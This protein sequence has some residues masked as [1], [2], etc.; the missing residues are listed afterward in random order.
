M[1]RSM[2]GYGRCQEVIDG[3]DITVEIRSVN[4]RYFE[5]SSRV[6]RVYGYLDEK[7]KSY[8]QSG[9]SRGKVEVGV[10][11]INLN[12]AGADVQIN[13][14]L[15]AAYLNSLRSMGKELGLQDDVTITSLARFNDIFTVSRVQED[16]DVIW[17]AVRQVADKA[18]EAFVG[19]REREG[20]R[21]KE[22]LLNRLVSI[23]KN[24]ALVEEQS[25][26]TVE[27]YRARLYAK[28]SEVLNNTA[29]DE[30]RI[31]TEAAIFAEKIAVA[32]ETVRLG[33]HIK[34][35][36]EILDSSE[37]IGRKLDFLVQEFNREANTIG[38]KAQDV[39]VARIVVDIKSDIEKIREQI[40]NIE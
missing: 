10:T 18:L 20:Q 27:N 15:A 5:F 17:D 28:L 37:P 23:E 11:V 32:E 33:S 22:D 6:P 9:I 39:A 36:R 31:L 34:Q 24:V 1:I 19:M 38:S 12:G 13:T 14:D 25:P 30:Q 21:M 35:F 40:Q 2:T 4:H 16:E 26:K 8:L 7:L 3:R 29:I